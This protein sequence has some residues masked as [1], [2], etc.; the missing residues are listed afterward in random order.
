[1][2]RTN[3]DIDDAL[4]ARVMRR[5]G[6]PTKRAAVDL[7]LRRLDIEPLTREEALA[8]RGSGWEGDLDQLRGDYAS[9]GS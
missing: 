8:M 4:I 6:L 1:M 2:T 7:A 3:V 9:A 5:H